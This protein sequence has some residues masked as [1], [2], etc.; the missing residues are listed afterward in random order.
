MDGDAACWPLSSIS[1]GWTRSCAG[2]VVS[3][4]ESVNPFTLLQELLGGSLSFFY[5]LIPNY[6]MAIIL[7]TIAVSLLLFPLTLKQTRSMKS[8]QE[9]QPEVKKIQKELKGDREELNKQLMALYKEKGVNPA[10]GCLP[11]LAQ[12]PIWFAL[13]RVLRIGV[14][15]SGLALTSDAIP[16]GDLADALIAGKTS[17]L[18]MDLLVSPGTAFAEGAVAA[19]PYIVLVVFVIVTGY[20]QQWQMSRRRTD[21]KEQSQQQQTMQTVMKIMPLFLGFISWTFPS[22]LVL[23][24]GASAL[25]RIGQQSVILR[26]GDADKSKDDGAEQDGPAESSSPDSGGGDQGK[27]RKG[28][29]PH[30]SKKRK[31]RRRK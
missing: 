26:I 25:F 15:D 31:K 23:Y 1:R 29:S 27:K 16:N 14:D 12:L 9:I 3:R 28:P 2:S 19:I 21:D 17:F 5:T 13:F 22:G 6:G 20:Y 30:A 7:L 24:F 18:N 8:M 11:L 4:G 10:A